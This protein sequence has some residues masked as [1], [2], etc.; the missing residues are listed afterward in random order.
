MHRAK[1]VKAPT[2]PA[3]LKVQVGWNMIEMFDKS[4]D[5]DFESQ[6]AMVDK[7]LS[8]CAANFVDQVAKSL[9]MKL[10]LHLLEVTQVNLFMLLLSNALDNIMQYTNVFIPMRHVYFIA[11]LVCCG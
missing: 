1:G 6:R 11:S 5:V 4:T 10:E 7:L 8:S 2:R 9:H 3:A